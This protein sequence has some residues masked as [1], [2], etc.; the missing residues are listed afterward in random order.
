MVSLSYVFI[1]GIIYPF[2]KSC[3]GCKNLVVCENSGYPS[4]S[5]P[6]APIIGRVRGTNEYYRVDL[7][8]RLDS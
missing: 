8:D 2:N 3:T 7:R 1:P 4:N 6:N 5:Q